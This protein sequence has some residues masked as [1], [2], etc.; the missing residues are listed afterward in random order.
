MGEQKLPLRR[1][2]GCGQERLEQ[3]D[4]L[5]WAILHW[6]IYICECVIH[7]KNEAHDL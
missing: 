1:M 2:G 3:K 6:T 4:S 7:S 5:L